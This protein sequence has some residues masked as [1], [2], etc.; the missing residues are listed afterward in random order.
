MGIPKEE[1]KRRLHQRLLQKNGHYAE[2]IEYT[3]SEHIIFLWDNKAVS[4]GSYERF[5][6]GIITYKISDISRCIGD[7]KEQKNGHTAEIIEGPAS[8]NITVRFEDGTIVKNT[9]FYQWEQGIIRYP[10]KYE[11]RRNNHVG[12]QKMQKN[13]YIFVIDSVE[14]TNMVHGHFLDGEDTKVTTSIKVFNKGTVPHPDGDE[15][16]IRQKKERLGSSIIQ[17]NGLSLTIDR[18][19]TSQD[20]G[21][22]FEDGTR[23]EKFKYYKASTGHIGHPTLSSF[24]H[25]TYMGF[26]TFPAFT[27]EKTVYYKCK[28]SK[29][30][31]EDIMTPQDMMKHDKT[32]D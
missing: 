17:S 15:E 32:C 20:C 13:G 23:V 22:Y 6:N 9:T 11:E 19:R 28:C 2:I 7:K 31:M 25:G 27:E 10:A 29:C 4:R 16:Q 12:T 3:D 21:G 24:G 30:G 5:K 1:I 8:G 14:H 26:D 18:Y